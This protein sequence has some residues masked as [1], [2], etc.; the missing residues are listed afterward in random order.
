MGIQVAAIPVMETISGLNPTNNVKRFD[1]QDLYFNVL[2][3]TCLQDSEG[4]HA[5]WQ[6]LTRVHSC[7][8]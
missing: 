1:A 8:A 2:R 6:V 4:M 5:Q 7:R 3:L